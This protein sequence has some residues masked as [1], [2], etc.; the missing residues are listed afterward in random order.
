M[1]LCGYFVQNIEQKSE[2]RLELTYDN[3]CFRFLK[4]Y[5]ISK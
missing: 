1:N 3:F 2:L 4:N 5:F